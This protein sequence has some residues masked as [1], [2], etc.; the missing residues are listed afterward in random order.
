[1]NC[2]VAITLLS[3]GVVLKQSQP[4]DLDLMNYLSQPGAPIV[5]VFQFKTLMV[6]AVYGWKRLNQSE[7]KL[8]EMIRQFS[9]IKHSQRCVRI[10]LNIATSGEDR[11]ARRFLKLIRLV[12]HDISGAPVIDSSGSFDYVKIFLRQSLLRLGPGHLVVLSLTYVPIIVLLGNLCIY[13]GFLLF[14]QG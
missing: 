4:V 11:V 5:L 14:A 9:S 12:M 2:L 3:E 6:E 7:R 10:S 13:N 8:F 1:M